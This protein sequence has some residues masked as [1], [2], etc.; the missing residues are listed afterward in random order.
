MKTPASFWAAPRLSHIIL[1][2]IATAGFLMADAASRMDVINAAEVENAVLQKTMAEVAPVN[3][4]QRQ[5]TL[6]RP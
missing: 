1:S 2:L 6:V 4:V 3:P 5:A